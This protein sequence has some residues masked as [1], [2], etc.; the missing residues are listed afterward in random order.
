MST[1]L[2]ISSIQEIPEAKKYLMMTFVEMIT[3]W[4]AKQ[5]Q[6]RIALI[7]WM[8]L[9]IVLIF[10]KSGFPPSQGLLSK[11]LVLSSS[12]LTVSVLVI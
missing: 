6:A 11:T 8:T 1:L 5:A 3:T 12:F 9:K 4:K 2:E 7:K 10:I